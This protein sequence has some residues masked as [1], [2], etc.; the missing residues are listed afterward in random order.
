MHKC[1]FVKVMSRR[2][3][4]ASN[5]T[6]LFLARCSPS[7]QV[8]DNFLAVRWLAIMMTAN[9]IPASLWPTCYSSLSTYLLTF[10]GTTL[11]FRS[12]KNSQTHPFSTI[13][14]RQLDTTLYATVSVCKVYHH[15]LAE[16]VKWLTKFIN[17]LLCDETGDPLTLFLYLFCLITRF[18]KNGIWH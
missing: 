17:S 16:D 9:I 10:S 5:N 4:H 1:M 8:D 2:Q 14:L 7:P 11:F 13:F 15:I 3:S 18:R 6:S 12:K